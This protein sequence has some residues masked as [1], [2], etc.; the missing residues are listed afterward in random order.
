VDCLP[1]RH[2]ALERRQVRDV[3]LYELNGREFVGAHDQ[4]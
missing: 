4:L 2:Q 1:R 3:F